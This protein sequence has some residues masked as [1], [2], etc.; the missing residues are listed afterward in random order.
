M[1]KMKVWVVCQ[2]VENEF[3]SLC[4]VFSDEQ[5]AQLAADIVNAPC[6]IGS[7]NINSLEAA[8]SELITWPDAYLWPKSKDC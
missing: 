3:V 7:M 4:G 1:I 6:S 8:T 2:V 5:K